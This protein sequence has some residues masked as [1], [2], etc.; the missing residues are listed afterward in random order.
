MGD[1]GMDVVY[2]DHGAIP[3]ASLGNLLRGKWGGSRQFCRGLAERWCRL[4]CGIDQQ[5][6][7]HCHPGAHQTSFAGFYWDAYLVKFNSG[8]TRLWGT[9]YGGGDYDYG[10]SV[11]V[12]P[13]DGAVYLAGYT[14]SPTGIATSSAHQTS[15]ADTFDAFLVKFNSGGTRLWGTYYGGVGRKA[16]MKLSR[17]RR[18]MV[19]STLRE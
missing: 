14:A 9:Y 4:P 18:A 10:N 17:S 8:G 16:S 19:P 12:S 5:H 13:S 15:Y 2:A 1:L 11:A 3:S 7:R 6:H